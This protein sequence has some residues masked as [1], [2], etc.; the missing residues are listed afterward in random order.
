M[1]CES[2]GRPLSLTW[3][4][5]SFPEIMTLRIENDEY[6]SRHLELEVF[7][8]VLG[9][10]AIRQDWTEQLNQACALR[11]QLPWITGNI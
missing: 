1:A 4:M 9:E 11:C 6:S 5:A 2:L 3:I 10:P 7:V 8:G